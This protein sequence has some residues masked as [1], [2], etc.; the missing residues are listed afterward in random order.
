MYCFELASSASLYYSLFSVLLF[1]VMFLQFWERENLNACIVVSSL[2]L[3]VFVLFAW[4]LCCQSDNFSLKFRILHHTMLHRKW[5]QVHVAL[6]S[7]GDRCSDLYIYS[8]IYSMYS[9]HTASAQQNSVHWTHWT[10]HC[11]ALYA[12]Q[13]WMRRYMWTVH[14]MVCFQIQQIVDSTIVHAV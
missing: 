14:C 7:R 1:P 5:C 11:T 12:L 10:F 8:S 9:S 6:L 13:A 3:F 2:V 4:K